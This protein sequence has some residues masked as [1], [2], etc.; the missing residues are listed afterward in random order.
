VAEDLSTSVR[1]ELLM[2]ERTDSGDL[3]FIGQE[4]LMLYAE[5]ATVRPVE[6]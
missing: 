3:L 2:L 6:D 4:G 1:R 5:L